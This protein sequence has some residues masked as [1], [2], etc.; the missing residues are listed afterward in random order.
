MIG[1]ME[2]LVSGTNAS[3]GVTPSP[4]QSAL[5][6]AVRGQTGANGDGGPGATGSRSAEV[7]HRRRGAVEL[8][9]GSNQQLT[10][11]GIVVPKKGKNYRGVRQRPWGKWAAEIRDP[12]VGARRW[13]GTFDT[14]VEAARAYDAAA[15]AIRGSA[16]RCNFPLPED[17]DPQAPQTLGGQLSVF[18][19]ER[20]ASVAVDKPSH[21]P[22]QKQER[23]QL[24]VS[25]IGGAIKDSNGENPRQAK[26]GAFK[27]PR[28]AKGA[29]GNQ[30][31]KTA[32]QATASLE[33]HVISWAESSMEESDICSVEE[34]PLIPTEK[35]RMDASELPTGVMPI[36]RPQAIPNEFSGRRMGGL[37]INNAGLTPPEGWK[38]PQSVP[39]GLS[40][41]SRSGT[42]FGSQ[43]RSV[44]LMDMCTRIM[45]AGNMDGL[46][47]GSLPIDEPASGNFSLPGA[48]SDAEGAKDDAQKAKN[49][50]LD[51]TLMYEPMLSVSTSV[52]TPL[53]SEDTGPKPWMKGAATNNAAPFPNV[54]PMVGFGFGM[55]P[56]F[57]GPCISSHG[58]EGVGQAMMAPTPGVSLIPPMGMGPG[59]VTWPTAMGGVPGFGHIGFP[60]MGAWMGTTA[61]GRPAQS[62]EHV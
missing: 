36:S 52:T 60:P 55:T 7:R 24:E 5:T 15:R 10:P 39:T 62:Q 58:L 49:E 17:G 40:P 4:C 29:Q 12:S 28:G 18:K 25:P 27:Q 6:M 59:D 44:D 34:D 3:T 51:D 46:S 8:S 38:T 23:H 31:M 14:A 9:K 30:Q 41:R 56:Y 61:L 19:G 54:H 43:G 2:P 53:S 50:E 13:L 57:G 42:P 20:A 37:P 47:I 1:A 26:S 11:G 32:E 21:N 45:E 22:M 35:L 16:A 33:E 48:I